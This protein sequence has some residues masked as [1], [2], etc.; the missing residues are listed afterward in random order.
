MVETEIFCVGH[1]DDRIDTK[2][3]AKL[4]TQECQYDGQRVGDSCRLNHHIV[5][6]RFTTQQPV[7]SIN[8]IVVNRAA[9]TSIAQF[10]HIAGGDNELVVDCYVAKFVEH[11]R[12][13]EILL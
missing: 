10:H 5:E 1:G 4:R 7:K 3:L 12:N 13:L 2:Q 9:D 8:K 6:V 11:Y